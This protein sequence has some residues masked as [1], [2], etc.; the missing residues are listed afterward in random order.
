VPSRTATMIPQTVVEPQGNLPSLPRFQ[1]WVP[2]E[3]GTAGI[4]AGMWPCGTITMLGELFGAE[5]KGQVYGHLH[6]FLHD[7]HK[8]TPTLRKWQAI[9][10]SA[11][12][13]NGSI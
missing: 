7:N 3:I 5:S 4:L 12:H 11:C 2:S 10:D 9:H 6:S 8:L 1:G 13:S